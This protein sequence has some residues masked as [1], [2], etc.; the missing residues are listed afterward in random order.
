MLPSLSTQIPCGKMN[1]PSPKLFTRLPESS[2]FRIGATLSL[3]A[4]EFA[5][6]R[7]PTQMLLPSR[8][9][10]TALVDP[11]VLP[12]GSFAQPSTVRYG[13]GWELGAAFGCASAIAP[14]TVICAA[15]SV[16]LNRPACGIVALLA[17]A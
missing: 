4:Q 7:S 3:P 12:S 15:A 16:N 14:N 8:S 10:S 9:I 1:I 13:L 11:Q 17:F 6:H 2:N 5:P